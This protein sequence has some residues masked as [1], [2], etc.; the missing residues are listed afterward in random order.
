MPLY[1]LED[2]VA[3]N[4]AATATKNKS[5]V[6]VTTT[7]VRV[8]AANPSRK[9]ATFY[10]TDASRQVYL[11][12]GGTVSASAALAK[13]GAKSVYVSDIN[14]TGEFWAVASAGTASLEVEEYT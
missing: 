13:I 5:T 4:P 9:S 14:W 10:N 11:N 2:V 12:T 7:A 6:A 8:L 3:V 1:S